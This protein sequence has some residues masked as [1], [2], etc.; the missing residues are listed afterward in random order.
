MNVINVVKPLYMTNL[1]G[2]IKEQIMERNI[3]NIINVVKPL[4]R[5]VIFKPIK[6]YI[7][8]CNLPPSAQS[9]PCSSRTS[10]P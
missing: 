5:A 8:E 6:Y 10:R 9:L 7:L 3:T 2:C 4:Q 1:L